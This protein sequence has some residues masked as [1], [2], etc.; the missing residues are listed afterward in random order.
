M[1]QEQAIEFL[2][3]HIQLQAV[4]NRIDLSTALDFALLDLQSRSGQI[5][6]QERCK[7]IAILTAA[8][9]DTDIEWKQYQQFAQLVAL[10]TQEY[11]L[12]Y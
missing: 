10:L 2:I 8:V 7:A 9:T 6:W 5:S 4:I 12:S 1:S 3:V 11:C